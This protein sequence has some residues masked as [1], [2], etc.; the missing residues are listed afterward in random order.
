M[1]LCIFSQRPYFSGP[2]L[3]KYTSLSVWDLKGSLKIMRTRYKV[4][5][6]SYFIKCYI[7]KFM[8]C[9]CESKRRRFKIQRWS[10][11][12][13]CKPQLFQFKRCWLRVNCE[14]YSQCR[15][16]KVSHWR[17]MTIARNVESIVGDVYPVLE[18]LEI[19]VHR[20]RSKLKFCRCKYHHYKSLS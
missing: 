9:G 20:W 5:R 16:S 11:S 8:L 19:L 14:I 4:D 7:F 6:F 10:C 17:C 12:Y 15:I 3:K 18:I 2:S 13:R 1:L